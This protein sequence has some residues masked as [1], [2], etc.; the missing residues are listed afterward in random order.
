MAIYRE[1]ARGLFGGP[2]T[3]PVPART[4]QKPVTRTAAPVQPG[5]AM[6]AAATADASSFAAKPMF[7]A[8]AGERRTA[9]STSSRKPLMIGA[10]IAVAALAVAGIAFVTTMDRTPAESALLTTPPAATPTPVPAPTPAPIVPAE[11][12]PAPPVAS[13]PTPEAA[14][15]PARRTAS[16]PARR[17]APVRSAPAAT[18]AEPVA[19]PAPTLGAPATVTLTPA[20]PAA[21]PI[22]TPEPAPVPAPV[23]EPVPQ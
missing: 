20:T 13:T 10:G 9:R 21:P 11:P 8:P 17:T 3:A 2:E 19:P 4:P 18:P 14:P 16:A 12:I 5:P 1:T 23:P 15:P 7:G 6:A 22:V